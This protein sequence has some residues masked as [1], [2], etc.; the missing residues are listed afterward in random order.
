[1]R[2][3]KAKPVR[4]QKA[5][6]KAQA[7]LPATPSERTLGQLL[8]EWLAHRQ[9][10]GLS[11]T[12]IRG[13]QRMGRSQCLGAGWQDRIED[14][15]VRPGADDPSGR[16]R[17]D[18]AANRWDQAMDRA[19]HAHIPLPTDPTMEGALTVPSSWYVWSSRASGDSWRTPDRVSRAFARACQ[20]LDAAASRV[21]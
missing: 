7:Q 9:G 4:A 12:I 16:C 2:A 21:P 5:E 1:V 8:D 20:G 15:Q 3:G 18:T 10:L 19:R 11:P 13:Y 14:D 17:H 6:A